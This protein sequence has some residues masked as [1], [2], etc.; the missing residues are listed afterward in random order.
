MTPADHAMDRERLTELLQ[1][2]ARAGSNDLAGL[3]AMAE[4]FPWFSGARLLLAVG[5]NGSGSVLAAEDQGSAA[6]HL[7]SRTVLF[8]L[9]RAAADN[10]PAQL[11]TAWKDAPKDAAT[12][13]AALPESFAASPEKTAKTGDPEP[14]L[15]A[16][17]ASS[18]PAGH[19]SPPANEAPQAEGWQAQLT[20]ATTTDELDGPDGGEGLNTRPAADAPPPMRHAQAAPA[21]PDGKGQPDRERDF[22][23]N[24]FVE[25]LATTSYDIGQW[26]TP[27]PPPPAAAITQPTPV[28]AGQ[29][30]EH[31]R[32]GADRE[33]APSPAPMHTAPMAKMRFTDWLEQNPGTQQAPAVQT[34]PVP[35]RTAS[36]APAPPVTDQRELMDRFIG[37]ATPAPTAVKAAFFN[38]QKAAKR[39]LQD[40][41]MV[42]ETLARVHEKQGNFTK[43]REVY[44]RLATLHPEKSVYFAALSKALEG[45]SNK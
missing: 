6:A 37:Q 26:G 38:P 8:D 21:R 28:P 32:G 27:P 10:L 30:R 3:R 11:R 23:D 15:H 4:R 34:P 40:A 39:S 20:V 2:P 35:H 24:L 25:A 5:E 41:G 29:P 44:D 33:T 43:A 42:S 16:P 17:P 19:P 13:S 31:S 36:G 22:L 14:V 9:I 1:H 7:P 18:D 45:R 12:S